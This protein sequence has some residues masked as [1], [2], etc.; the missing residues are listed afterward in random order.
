LLKQLALV[1]TDNETR[2]TMN[3]H[4]FIK[5]ELEIELNNPHIP[6]EEEIT[7]MLDERDDAANNEPIEEVDNVQ[8][9]EVVIDKVRYKDVESA[10]VTLK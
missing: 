7:S 2:P 6:I 8:I 4:E 10:L 3:A 1:F 9:G 5:D